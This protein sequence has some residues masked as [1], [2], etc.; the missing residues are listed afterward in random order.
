M[1][2]QCSNI[3]AAVTNQ[4]QQLIVAVKQAIDE[5]V[6]KSGQMTAD[7]MTAL[8]EG[9]KDEVVGDV[10]R[11]LD[12]LRSSLPSSQAET[13]VDWDGG[14]DRRANFSDTGCLYTYGF[15]IY[16]VPANFVFPN[17]VKFK[18]G[19]ELWLKGQTNC[20]DNSTFI[21]PYRNLQVAMLPT[22]KLKDGFKLSWRYLF[23]IFEGNAFR[24][25]PQDTR[26]LSVA[27]MTR[28]HTLCLDKLKQIFSYYFQA[29]K[30]PHSW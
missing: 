20:V 5:K 11:K 30:R 26:T 16:H 19:L 7:R 18:Q 1:I 28:Y 4:T 25:L 13:V 24:D 17:K 8:L 14:I 29:Q 27:E 21:R 23:L 3:F 9:F 12:D 22:K 6:F 15:R 2:E 10:T